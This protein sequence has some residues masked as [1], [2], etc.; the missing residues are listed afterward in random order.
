MSC[1]EFPN[2]LV[3]LSWGK[4]YGHKQTWKNGTDVGNDL[5][6]ISTL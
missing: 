6:K 1:D 5:M 4:I 3:L 2:T